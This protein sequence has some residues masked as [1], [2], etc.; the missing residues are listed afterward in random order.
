MLALPEL[1]ELY[2]VSDIHMGGAPGFQI[3]REG[4]RLGKLIA[5]LATTRPGERLG[6]V[7]NGDVIDSLAEDIEGYI[8]IDDA[9]RMMAR[10]YADP[11]FAPVW[12]GLAAFVRQPGRR[13]VIV[14]GNH[15]IEMALPLVEASIRSRLTGGDETASGRITFATHGSGF[16]CLVGRAR[17]F[18]THGNEV[19]AWNLIDHDALRSLAMSQA[20][21]TSYDRSSW[22]PN[23]GT[24]LVKEVMN[25][26]KQKYA[27]ID[28]L[29]PETEAALGVLLVLDPGQALKVQRIRGAL[30][31]YVNKMKGG[32][33][34]SGWLSAD[35]LAMA[36]VTSPEAVPVEQLL[37]PNLLSALRGGG[38]AGSDA[39]TM[40]RDAEHAIADPSRRRAIET[41]P[42][43]ETL[44]VGQWMWDRVNGIEPA[45]ALR[46]AL[47]DWLKDDTTWDISQ[48]DETCREVMKHVGPSVDFVVT[49][50]THLERALRIAPE[51]ERYYYNCGTWIRLLRLT[52]AVLASVDTFRDVYQTLVNGRMAAID[53]A[54]IP[55][56]A[57]GREPFV[58]DRSS[59]VRISARP[60]GTVGTLFHVLD[61]GPAGVDLEPVPGSEFW[62]K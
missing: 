53:S 46:R 31:A 52:D 60:D 26:I 35:Q 59:L 1:D 40:L 54:T 49:G 57:G 8:A 61:A 3:L 41:A 62:R 34:M 45:E 29:K 42:R 24:Q 14:L 11:T 20:A 27:W 17:V 33:K 4:P 36:P 22:E 7:L 5:K 15:D 21:G 48:T 12:E 50:H 6:L 30:S 16:G 18:C 9:D 25:G 38:S 10:L 55:A 37:G 2:V 43:L 13:L 19:D 39:D 51:A 44:G 23:A 56:A 28:L 58:I 47:R 32:F